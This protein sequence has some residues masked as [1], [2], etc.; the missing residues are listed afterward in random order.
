M[1]ADRVW[2][3]E[4]S[5]VDCVSRRD[6]V[7]NFGYVAGT[8]PSALIRFQSMAR[9]RSIW[10]GSRDAISKYWFPDYFRC[11]DYTILRRLKMHDMIQGVDGEN[12]SAVMWTSSYSD[13][14][15][16][17]A[18]QDSEF[19]SLNGG[20]G[21][22]FYSQNRIVVEDNLFRDSSYGFDLKAHVP[23]FDVRRNTFR[24]ISSYVLFGNMNTSGS[25]SLHLARFGSTISIRRTLLYARYQPR[26][27][28]RLRSL[29]A[30]TRWSGRLG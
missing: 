20:G 5:P 14:T 3:D 27:P 10:T 8:D 1:G 22:K 12:P 19:Y 23:R 18:V 7:I 13:S 15:D 24:N 16:F 28:G 25:G 4:A 2:H 26:R 6:S 29:S 9:R 30:A 21:L 17:C 11:S